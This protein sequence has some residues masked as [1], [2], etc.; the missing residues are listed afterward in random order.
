MKRRLIVCSDGT[1]QDLAKNYPTNVVKMAQAIQPLD[2]FSN[3]K[4][5]H[6]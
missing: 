1:W 4:F 6:K 3:H 2:S 5:V